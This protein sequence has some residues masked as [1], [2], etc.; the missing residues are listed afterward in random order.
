MGVDATGEPID[1]PDAPSY[2]DAPEEGLDLGMVERSAWKSWPLWAKMRLMRRLRTEGSGRPEQYID[3]TLIWYL[4]L[5]L[6]GRGSGKSDEASRWSAEDADRLPKIR[7]ALV[8]RTFADV[9]DTMFEGETGV[10]ALLPDYALR[11]GSRQRAY[12]RSLGELYLANGTKFKGFSSEKP[13]QLRGPQHHRA[14]LDEASS[15]D[16]A[17]VPNIVKANG[18]LAPAV[19]TTMSNLMLGLRLKAPDGSSVRMV[20]ATTPKPNELTEFMDAHPKAIVRVLSTYSNLKNLDSEVAEVVMSM[21]EGTEAAAQELEGIILRQAKGAAWDVAAVEAAKIRESFGEVARR[22]LG[23]DPAVSSK[24]TSDETGLVIVALEQAETE[25]DELIKGLCVEA[26]ASSVL[27]VSQFGEEV[28]SLIETHLIDVAVVEIN[29]GYDFVVNALTSHVEREGGTV[30]RR[31]R[32]DVRSA[33]TKTRVVVEY[34]C[35]TESGHAFII[36]P[37]WQSIDKLTR[38]KAASIWWHQGN[39]R[40]TRGLDK[41]EKQMTTY[42]G[43]AK[44][45]PDRLDALSSAVAEF[46]GERKKRSAR[47]ASPLDVDDAPLGS[48]PRHSLLGETMPELDPASPGR[49]GMATW[50]GRI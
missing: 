4:W 43:S 37:V 42:D 1:A 44:K 23:I 31:V 41:L 29:N 40:H 34:V 15:W 22:V 45:S 13:A 27:P 20:A 49:G 12:N 32:K 28:V 38:A 26:D 14:W 50:A 18:T 48:G 19:D 9:R 7:F 35:E 36:K 47:G 16:D 33:R 21:Y 5:L 10:L 11:G 25:G 6:G 39:A 3:D 24:D 30:V 17:D 8:A 2:E 46:S